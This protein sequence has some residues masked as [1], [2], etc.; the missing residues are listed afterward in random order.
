MNHSLK[1]KK[2]FHIKVFYLIDHQ[3]HYSLFIKSLPVRPVGAQG[4]VYVTDPQDSR[5]NG[6]FL[7]AFIGWIPAPVIIFMM[8]QNA[9]QNKIRVPLIFQLLIPQ[10]GMHPDV[11]QF[12]DHQWILLLSVD[13]A[14]KLQLSDIVKQSCLSK[15]VALLV[16]KAKLPCHCISQITHRNPV[17]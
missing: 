8:V 11:F 7:P 4:T 13:I 9:L 6:N 3:F 1:C 14:S 5:P 2:Y 12:L 15:L 17:F 10:T 16:W